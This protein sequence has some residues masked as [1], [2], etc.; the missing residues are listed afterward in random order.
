MF[1]NTFD[2]MIILHHNTQIGGGLLKPKVE[3]FGLFG[4]RKTVTPLK[5]KPTSMLTINEV[6][7][8]AWD[9]IKAIQTSEDLEASRNANPTICHFPNTVSLLPFITKALIWLKAPTAVDVFMATLEAANDFEKDIADTV[10]SATE[11]LKD[12]IP[13]L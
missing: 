10:P 7:S 5:Y 2:E 9:T 6:E 8:P 3:Q 4:G 1:K 12:I 13:Y 11:N